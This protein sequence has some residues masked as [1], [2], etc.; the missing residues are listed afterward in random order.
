VDDMLG[1]VSG[2]KA[3]SD[4]VEITDAAP[5]RRGDEDGPVIKSVFAIRAVAPGELGDSDREVAEGD[6]D[7][8]V[9][10]V[11]NLILRLRCRSKTCGIGY[12]T[13]KQKESMGCNSGGRSGELTPVSGHQFGWATSE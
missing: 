5:G 10:P 3:A 12:G 2:L 4:L 1:K 8:R 7:P 6:L 9:P 11:Y 13:G